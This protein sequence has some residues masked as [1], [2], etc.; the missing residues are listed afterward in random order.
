MTFISTTLGLRGGSQKMPL[1]SP[2]GSVLSFNGEVRFVNVQRLLFAHMRWRMQ[3]EWMFRTGT[4]LQTK[5]TN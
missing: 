1:V 4:P 2:L 5:N 3:S